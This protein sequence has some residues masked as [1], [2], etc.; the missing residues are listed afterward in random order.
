MAEPIELTEQE[1]EQ[2]ERKIARLRATPEERAKILAGGEPFDLDAWLREVG[3]ARPDELE[4]MEELLRER[5]EERRRGL[6]AED[7][8]LAGRTR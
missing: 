6:T 4:E 2:F 7:E 8:Q 1:R 5:A 3:P